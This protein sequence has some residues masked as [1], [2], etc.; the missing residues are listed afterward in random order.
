MVNTYLYGLD[1]V[2]ISW[3]HDIMVSLCRH[4]YV[5]I[6]PLHGHTYDIMIP[7]SGYN[8]DIM[9]LF[10]YDNDIIDICAYKTAYKTTMY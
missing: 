7:L 9:I 4:D 2:R 10:G 8:N 3:Y 5:V 6:I 1:L